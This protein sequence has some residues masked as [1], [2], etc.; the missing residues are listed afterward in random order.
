MNNYEIKVDIEPKDSYEKTLNLLRNTYNEFQ[1]LTQQEK[2]KL[3][4]EFANDIGINELTQF[5]QRYF[6]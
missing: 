2:Q 4:L 3:I 6:Q 1:K 5:L